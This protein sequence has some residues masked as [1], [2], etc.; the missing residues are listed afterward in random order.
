MHVFYDFETSGLEPA[1]EQVLQFAAIYTDDAF[2]EI[3]IINECCQIRKDVI[4]SRPGDI[5]FSFRDTKISTVGIAT[6]YC[7]DAVKPEEFGHQGIYWNSSGWGVD[8]AY[9]QL[10]KPIH[11]TSHTLAFNIAEILREP[12]LFQEP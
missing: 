3:E 1:F 5:I 10:E 2:N 11:P 4:P 8:I 7:Y 6:S 12:G 9:Q